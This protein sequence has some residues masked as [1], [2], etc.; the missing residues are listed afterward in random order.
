MRIARAA[1]YDVAFIRSVYAYGD[2][3]SKTSDDKSPP[4][5]Q[6]P[7]LAAIENQAIFFLIPINE[8]NERI[9][10]FLYHPWNTVTYEMHSAIF[11]EYRGE[12]AFDAAVSAAMW[13]FTMTPCKKIVTLIP[14]TNYAARAL[15]QKGGMLKEGIV[16]ASYLKGGKLVDQYL[17]GMTKEAM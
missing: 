6:I 14:K 3:W 4:L 5:E 12:Q 9:G 2:I 15:A 13:M 11:P 8:D 10:C 16:T 1:T 17:Y 7:F